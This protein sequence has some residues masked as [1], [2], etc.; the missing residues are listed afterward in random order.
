MKPTRTW[1]LIA[2]GARARILENLG[3]GKGVHE[4]PDMTI[5]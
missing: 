2:D 1:I 5:A 4:V 3:P